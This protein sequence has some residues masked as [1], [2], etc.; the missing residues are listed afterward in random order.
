MVA[1]HHTFPTAVRLPGVCYGHAGL[2]TGQHLRSRRHWCI[3]TLLSHWHGVAVPGSLN[4]VDFFFRLFFVYEVDS[5]TML[6][7]DSERRR[8]VV[9]INLSTQKIATQKISTQFFVVFL[10]VC[11]DTHRRTQQFFVVILL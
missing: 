7:G 4:F 3:A 2:A 8:P 9:M 1:V 10:R 5:I 11:G 6:A